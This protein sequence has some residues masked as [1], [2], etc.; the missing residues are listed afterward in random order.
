METFCKG[1][2][3]DPKTLLGMTMNGQLL[4]A[5]CPGAPL[6]AM[7]LTLTDLQRLQDRQG[8]QGRQCLQGNNQA[9][10]VAQNRHLRR[11]NQGKDNR[12][13][14][15]HRRRRRRRRHHRRQQRLHQH[16]RRHLK[17]A[18]HL[19]YAAYYNH[20]DHT[21]YNTDLHVNCAAYNRCRH[22][23][24]SG[25]AN[26]YGYSTNERNHVCAVNNAVHNAAHNDTE[27]L[28]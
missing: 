3:V 24:F 17:L 1:V 6:P 9:C 22:K 25:A 28:W 5:L 13:H 8:L 18:R 21:A 20:N 10:P 2:A 14:H 26:D 19:D 16:F 23:R 27:R 11:E 12:Q 4:L 7:T 15:L